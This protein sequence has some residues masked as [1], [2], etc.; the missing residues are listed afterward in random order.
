MPPDEERTREPSTAGRL[1][2]ELI[3][4]ALL[5]LAELIETPQAAGSLAQFDPATLR[6]QA[7]AVLDQLAKSDSCPIDDCLT[8]DNLARRGE[9]LME[10]G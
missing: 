5:V 7:V 10:N 3:G 9:R 6:H 2:P 4:A 1:D 8:G